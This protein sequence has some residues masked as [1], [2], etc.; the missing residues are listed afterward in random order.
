MWIVGVIVIGFLVGLLA[1]F[2][3]PGKDRMGFVLT[4]LLGVVGAFVA[5]VIGQTMGF[6]GYGQPA[7]FIASVLGA[8]AV[9]VVYRMVQR[10]K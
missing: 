3:M 5:T 1:R 9:L 6:Y 10:E 2:F 4:T 8:M 7:G